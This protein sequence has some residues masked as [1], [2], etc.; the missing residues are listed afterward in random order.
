MSPSPTMEIVSSEALISP[1]TAT[2]S[3]ASPITTTT[4]ASSSG[5]TPVPSAGSTTKKGGKTK[6]KP[7]AKKRK[8]GDDESN[9]TANEVM[10]LEKTVDFYKNEYNEAL[11]KLNDQET[12]EIDQETEY[13]R[14]IAKKDEKIRIQDVNIGEGEE[15]IVHLRATIRELVAE[16]EQV[17]QRLADKE[18]AERESEEAEADRQFIARQNAF[19]DLLNRYEP[20]FP[21]KYKKF[22]SY[23]RYRRKSSAPVGD[24]KH[25]T[26]RS[27]YAG[28]QGDSNRYKSSF[29]F[30]CKNLYSNPRYCSKVSGPVSGEKYKIPRI[31]TER[32]PYASGQHDL[33]PVGALPT[34]ASHSWGRVATAP[35]IQMRT[36][37]PPT[38]QTGGSN[39][40]TKLPPVCRKFLNGDCSFGASCRFIHISEGKLPAYSSNGNSNFIIHRGE[41]KNHGVAATGQIPGSSARGSG[42]H[43]CKSDHGRP[44]PQVDAEFKNSLTQ[45]SRFDVKNPKQVFNTQMYDE[46]LINKSFKTT[47]EY[48]RNFTYT[49]RTV[50]K[51]SSCK[52][53]NNRILEDSKP[54]K[55]KDLT[56]SSSSKTKK[57]LKPK[58]HFGNMNIMSNNIRGLGGKKA[59]LEDI[60]ETNNVDICCV[61][62]VNNKN[63][64]RFKN[65][66]Q[67]N[68]FSKLRMHGVMMLVHNSLRQHAIRVPDESELECVHVRLNHTT[69]ALNIIGL[70]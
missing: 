32:S 4:T 58:P 22:Y 41:T 23:P 50:T 42:G 36:I 63:P 68:R 30:K 65:Y 49:D 45:G 18:K 37:T 5:S 57:Q 66:V 55:I 53:E 19:R 64:P 56:R 21:L 31:T 6:V 60:L 40:Y 52:Q 34:S 62:E 25:T 26:E 47:R 10:Q 29:L 28:G 38:R 3:I 54:S 35:D 59:S 15:E 12:R 24:E 1:P 39:R 70:Y 48:S 7:E 2:P 13:L 46:I 20:S 16:N 27:P 11:V 67:F 17:R 14:I 33:S 8:I 61:Q 9:D 44:K 43:G 69:P 51:T